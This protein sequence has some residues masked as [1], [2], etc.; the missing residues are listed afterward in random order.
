MTIIRPVHE[1]SGDARRLR[2]AR[3]PLMTQLPSLQAQKTRG[4]PPKG[5]LA[6]NFDTQRIP[7]LQPLVDEPGADAII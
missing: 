5:V 1:G 3:F 6:K 2:S 4:E 7:N